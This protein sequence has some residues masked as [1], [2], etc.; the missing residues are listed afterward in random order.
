VRLVQEDRGHGLA[1]WSPDGNW[2][3]H[4]YA[5]PGT[6]G[7]AK[8]KV[9]TG[10]SPIDVSNV[11]PVRSQDSPK[12][13][14]TGNWISCQ[15]QEGLVLVSPDGKHKRIL[16]TDLPIIHGWSKDGSRIYTI[17]DAE[18]LHL[19]L[20]S[21][22]IENLKETRLSEVGSSLNLASVLGFSMNPDGKSFATSMEYWNSDLWLLE[23][24]NMRP[25]LR[26]RLFGD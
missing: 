17:R 5:I 20:T 9:G 6:F 13:S 15:T 24:F 16:S 8:I 7:L 10:E 21:I 3:A 12:W 26:N 4:V 1:T 18:S 2:I 19:I 22:D 11:V 14:P 25:S 23:G